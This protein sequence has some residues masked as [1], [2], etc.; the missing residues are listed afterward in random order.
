MLRRIHP[1]NLRLLTQPQTNGCIYS[2]E[3][4]PAHPKCI[5]TDHH[6]ADN[7]GHKLPGVAAKEAVHTAGVHCSGGE[8]TETDGAQQ[9][10]NPMDADHIKRIVEL[11][12]HLHADEGIA[13]GTT[14]Q[15]D[16]YRR[17]GP[18]KTGRRGNGRQSGNG[19]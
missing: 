10:T 18:D 6:G 7:L 3:Y 1:S 9:A 2:F 19:P 13:E 11:E 5:D 12:F 16:Q 8:Q 4:K 14:K 15:A 17:I